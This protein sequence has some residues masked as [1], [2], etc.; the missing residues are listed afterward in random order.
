MSLTTSLSGTGTVRLGNTIHDPLDEIEVVEV[1]QATYI[2]G[3]LAAR[4]RSIA[5]VP[6]DEFLPFAHGRL[7]YWPALDT[8]SD[9]ATAAV[10]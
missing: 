3:T 4:C 8:S 7:D 6:A 5:R 1:R 2:E 10:T 9:R